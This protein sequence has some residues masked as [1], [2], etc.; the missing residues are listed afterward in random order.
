LKA[1]E[2]SL[3][4]YQKITGIVSLS[5]ETRLS[6]ERLGTFDMEIHDSKANI[7]ALAGQARGLEEELTSIGA[8]YVSL[9]G[10]EVD[11]EVHNIL[12]EIEKDETE[13]SL[14]EKG[15][16]DYTEMT[17][18]ISDL[19]A[20]LRDRITLL[21][22][23]DKLNDYPQYTDL[24]NRLSLVR[25]EQVAEKAKLAALQKL[26][27]EEQSGLDILPEREMEFARLSRLVSMYETRYLNI[28]Q[29]IE[30][31][32]IAM[33]VNL[34]EVT[35]LEQAVPPKYPLYPQILLNLILAVIAGIILSVFVIIGAEIFKRHLW[36]VR[37]VSNVLP[38]AD[39]CGTFGD[40]NL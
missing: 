40:W 9:P 2:D 8:G 30:D 21:F 29:Q 32:K 38:D 28:E 18:K 3:E 11:P 6:L 4:N 23:A 33:A 37:E 35:L 12:N 27:K 36:T 19:K 20:K 39:Y 16:G 22:G 14:M 31:M 1:A 25:A 7:E 26:E 15:S 17:R 10:V 24:S 34:S 5:D 13:L